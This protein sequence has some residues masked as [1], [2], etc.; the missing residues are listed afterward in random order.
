M[1]CRSPYSGRSVV[2]SQP[3]RDRLDRFV[4]RLM[5]DS[6]AGCAAPADN[7]TNGQSSEDHPGPAPVSLT[8]RVAVLK[9]ATAWWNARAGKAAKDSGDEPEQEPPEIVQLTDTLARRERRTSRG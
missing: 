4:I 3:L 2:M 1:D 5:D 7:V 6:E 9:A 8:E